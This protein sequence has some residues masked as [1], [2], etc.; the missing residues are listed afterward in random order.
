[1]QEFKEVLEE[2]N[3]K[4]IKYCVL[5][6]Y[7]FLLDSKEEKGFDFDVAVAEEDYPKLDEIFHNFSFIK[8][9]PQFSLKHQGFV[10]FIPAL[11]KKIGFDIQRGGI[12]WNDIPYLKAEKFLPRRVK[13]EFFYVLSPED[14]FIMYLCHSLLGKRYFKEKYKNLLIWLTRSELDF[15]YILTHLTTIFNLRIARQILTLV[16]NNQ[17]KRLEKKSLFYAG[18]FVL[19]H[20]LQIFS[21]FCL[22]LRWIKQQRWGI[23]SPLI[24]F[25]GPDGSG[26][27]TNALKLKKALEYNH[28]QVNLVYTGR[29]KSN[30][31]PIKSVGNLYK[32]YESKQEIKKKKSYFQSIIYTLAAP[33]YA[34]DLLLRYWF[35]IWPKRKFHYIVIT[36]RYCSDI[37]LMKHVPLFLKKGLLFFFPKPTI[38]FYMYNSA[39]VL[40]SRRKQQSVPELNRQMNL[41]SYLVDKFAAISIKT[42]Y[43]EKDFS[44]VEKKVFE[45]LIK[46]RK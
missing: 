19:H 27:S 13:K 7:E 25:I 35:I 43:P 40:Y 29:G 44:Q 33:V 5:R 21:F 46:K 30:L 20:P 37:L 41:F 8:S 6:N 28:R 39:E 16:K 2:F 14:A 26:K 31:I 1:M 38:T 15:D 22:F 4:G 10:K 42:S 17:F 23:S 32:T 3:R 9:P 18:Y 34:F 45:Y 24:S 11:H 36:D 12:Y